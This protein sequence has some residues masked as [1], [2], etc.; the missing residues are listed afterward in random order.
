MFEAPCTSPVVPSL[1]YA[2]AFNPK[3]EADP[4]VAAAASLGKAQTIA[5]RAMTIVLGQCFLKH[6][7]GGADC[8][9]LETS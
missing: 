6:F 4:L 2:K 9:P 1:A 8:I 5:C 7:Y 3:K